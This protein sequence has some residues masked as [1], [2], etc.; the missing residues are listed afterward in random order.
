M[1]KEEYAGKPDFP[2]MELVI[3]IGLHYLPAILP[4]LASGGGGSLSDG[5]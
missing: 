4:T 1:I 2:R 5:G 3:L